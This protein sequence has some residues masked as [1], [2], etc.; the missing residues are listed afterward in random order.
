MTR[1]YGGSDAVRKETMKVISYG[2]EL[3]RF[4]GKIVVYGGGIYGKYLYES[5][6]EYINPDDLV[7]CDQNS[8]VCQ[9]FPRYVC[10]GMLG[11]FSRK[12]PDA[13]M[14]IALYDEKVI[15]QVYQQMIKRGWAEHRIYQ[16]IPE[17][18]DTWME[19]KNREGFFNGDKNIFLLPSEEADEL[20]QS[21]IRGADPFLYSRWGGTEGNIVYRSRIGILE[22]SVYKSG[23]NNAGIFPP[24]DLVIR[25]YIDITEDA[26]RQI[27]VL[28]TGF[29]CRQ[30]EELFRIYSP[31][32]KLV[33]FG[34]GPGPWMYAL[35]GMKV[36][37]I[38]PFAALIEKQYL[39]REKLFRNPRVLPEF[40]LKTY[41]AIQSMGGNEEYGSWIEA[42]NKMEEDIS[43]IDFDIAL[44]GCGAYGMP[45]GA[46]I[47]RN[48]NKKALHIGGAL[49]IFFGIKGKRWDNEGIYNE[50]WIRPTDDL[51]P[52]NYKS[53]EDGCYW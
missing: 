13:V 33:Y 53:V 1:I 47:K 14:I 11:E 34:Q 16:Y 40:E 19:R 39:K 38:H 10:I 50:F 46:F 31:E 49:Q 29:W 18:E 21:L 48:L 12:Y 15:S 8:N 17:T 41:K 6:I 42:L 23:C 32:A 28:C 44:L 24:T 37:V 3:S 27:D 43:R 9:K 26:A 20:L 4:K 7:V 45:L 22:R 5:A 35:R 30:V 36:L 2:R 52:Q 25:N 51:K